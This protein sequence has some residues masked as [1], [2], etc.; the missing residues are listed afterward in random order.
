MNGLASNRHCPCKKL[1][2]DGPNMAFNLSYFLTNSCGEWSRRGGAAV[3][4]VTEV[5]LR[6]RALLT[7]HKINKRH[8]HRLGRSHNRML[9]SFFLPLHVPQPLRIKNRQQKQTSARVRLDSKVECCLPNLSNPFNWSGH[10]SRDSNLPSEHARLTH[11]T[12]KC[13]KLN[14]LGGCPWTGLRGLESRLLN[15]AAELHIVH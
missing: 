11:L 7:A 9:S 2:K 4:A 1:V 5:W 14:L 6:I 3:C 15:Y 12:L 13:A 10:C 8:P